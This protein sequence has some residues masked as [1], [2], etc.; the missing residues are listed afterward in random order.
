MV[1]N[2]VIVGLFSR[3]GWFA[4]R[5]MPGKGVEPLLH[6]SGDV[7]DDDDNRGEDQEEIFKEVVVGGHLVSF[8][9]LYNTS[10]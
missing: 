9:Y 2:E 7:S 1:E 8:R 5:A 3:L 10:V 4:L 6:Q